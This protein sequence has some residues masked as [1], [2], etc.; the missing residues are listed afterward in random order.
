MTH[1]ELLAKINKVFDEPH[2]RPD[3]TPMQ[4]VEALKAVVEL[5]KQVREWCNVC[6]ED[7]GGGWEWTNTL[8]PCRTIQAIE[9]KL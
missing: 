5:H 8:Y 6:L 9:E 2:I 4:A 3:F 1:D 7:D